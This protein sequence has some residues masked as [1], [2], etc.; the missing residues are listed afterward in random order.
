M[1]RVDAVVGEH[2]REGGNVAEGRALAELHPHPGAQLRE[3]V[4]P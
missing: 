2:R 4:L 1:P 3:R